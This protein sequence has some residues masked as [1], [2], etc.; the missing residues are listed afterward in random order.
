MEVLIKHLK[1]F[2]TEEAKL[3]EKHY[4]AELRLTEAI[5]R[6]DINEINSKLDKLQQTHS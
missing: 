6:S 2:I 1:K 5:I 3:R 4:L